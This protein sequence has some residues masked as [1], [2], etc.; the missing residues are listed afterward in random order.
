MKRSQA[1]LFTVMLLCSA[2]Y[3]HGQAWSGILKPTYGTGACSFR[4]VTSPGECAIDWSTAGVSGGIPSGTWT[5]SGSTIL[6]STY[7]NGSTDATSGI[8][9]ALNAC[10]TNHYVLLGAGTFLING[11]LSI[12]SNCVLRGAGSNQTILNTMGTSG[13]VFNMGTTG[14]VASGSTNITSGAT[15]GSTSIVVASATGISTGTYLMITELN[16]PVYV[17]ITTPNGTC[18]WCDASMWSGTRVRGQIVEVEGVNG[19]TITISPALYTDYGVAAGTSP[20]LATP[21]AASAKYAGVESLE[22]YANGTGYAQTYSLVACAYCWIKGVFDNY[23]DGDHVDDYFGFHDEIRDSYFSNAY[24]HTAGGSD[25]DV[26]ILAKTSGTLLENNILER[27]HA[28]TL[29]DWGS[30]GN[31]IAYNYFRGNFDSGGDLVILA[32]IGEHGAHSQ[33]NLFEGNVGNNIT[34]DSFWGS[35]SNETMFRNQFRGTETLASP[36]SGGRNVVNWAST[37]LANEQMFALTNSFCHVNLNS[38]GNVLGSADA[39]TAATSGLYNSGTSPFTSTVIPPA[40]RN[41]NNVFYAT[42]VGYNTGSDSSGSA[43]ASFAGGPSG[44]VGYWVGLAAST[45]LQHGNFDIASNSISWTSSIT[46]TLPAS[47]FLSSQP[48]FWTTAY[49][50]P[51][52][53]AIGPDVSGGPDSA[54]GGHANYIPAQLCYNN[55]S[56]DTTGLLIFNANTCYAAVSAPSPPSNVEA[57]AH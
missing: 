1:L 27:L 33:F 19:T 42:S 55:L 51:P 18:T 24:S 38:V 17:T 3:L 37:Q 4:Q 46:H 15:A 16:D 14:P 44:A 5:Q 21:F 52:W 36:L 23:T 34:H 10:G 48:S 53:P 56:R 31:V 11:N 13:A 7:G 35:S 2:G 29:V 57:V 43:V 40:T 41:Y 26:S 32:A 12:P 54:V 8:Q 9:T 30:A 25:A 45:I 22:A 20:A 6:A 39:V 49:G 28:G 47:F 50:T